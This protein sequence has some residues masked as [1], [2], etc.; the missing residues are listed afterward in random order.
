MYPSNDQW[1]APPASPPAGY[2]PPQ[3]Y[4]PPP[5]QWG[6]PPAPPGWGPAPQQPAQHRPAGPPPDPDELMSGGYKAAQFPDQAFG[7]VVGGPIVDKPVTS[8]QRD[9]DSGQLKFYDDGNPMWQIIVA[10]QAQPATVEDDG[11][12]AFYLKTQ[13]KKAVQEAVRLAGA[14][15]L[16]IGGVLQIR[17][18]R[19]EPNSRGR[20]K[21]KKIYEARYT[22]PADDAQPAPATGP[23]PS[24][25]AQLP[26]AEQ[27][28]LQSQF[29]PAPPF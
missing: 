11:I 7:T 26:A 9:F 29:N 17:Y 1:G 5:Q 14:T 16:E 10:V 19:D 18:V 24:V 15:R 2:G 20:G 8:Q 3:S 13:I 21:P 12:R 27:Q 28:Q 23:D 25:M 4:G 6:P 22:P